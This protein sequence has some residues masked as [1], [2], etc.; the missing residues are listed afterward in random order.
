MSILEYAVCL[1]DNL[2]EVWLDG[3]LLSGQP[4]QREALNVAEV[5]AHAAALRGERSKI[6]ANTPGGLTVEFPTIE[7]G[8]QHA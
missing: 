6:L 2:W 8:V 5:L 7:P 1:C 4:T 3:R